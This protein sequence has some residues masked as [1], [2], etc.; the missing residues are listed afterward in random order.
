MAPST[1]TR[2]A[3]YIGPLLSLKGLTA[4]VR[5]SS[6]PDCLLAQFDQIGLFHHDTALWNGWHTFLAADFQ[7]D[8]HYPAPVDSETYAD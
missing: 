5:P 2:H 1:G 8:P 6:Q 7:I 4:L 3:T